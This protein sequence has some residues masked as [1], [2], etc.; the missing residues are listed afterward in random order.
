MAVAVLGGW[1]VS[2]EQGIPVVRVCFWR[3]SRAWQLPRRGEVVS[4]I[5]YF[6]RGWRLM[7]KE[8]KFPLFEDDS[9]LAETPDFRG[10]LVQL[11]QPDKMR[12]S[13]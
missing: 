12:G 7:Q 11:H 8:K 9:F 6:S 13:L 2:Y 3:G 1:A 4:P 5:Y 10:P